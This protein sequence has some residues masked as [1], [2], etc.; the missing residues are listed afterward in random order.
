MIK[1]GDNTNINRKNNTMDKQNQS[2]IE[3]LK[4]NEP[5]NKPMKIQNK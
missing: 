2:L 5:N 4:L 3:N 1:F